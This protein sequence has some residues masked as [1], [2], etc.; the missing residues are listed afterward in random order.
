MHVGWIGY[1]RWWEP[2]FGDSLYWQGGHHGSHQS[3]MNRNFWS[4]GNPA[5]LAL[6]NSP[7]RYL[8]GSAGVATG[9]LTGEASG[10]GSD[11]NDGYSRLS[12]QLYDD[13]EHTG[14]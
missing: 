8:P 2:F 6:M 13:D 3:W 10:S 7:F 1:Y 11:D 9:A 5:G 12:F 4:K 14:I